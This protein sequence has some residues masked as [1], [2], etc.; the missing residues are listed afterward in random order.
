[1]SLAT[2]LRLT[3]LVLVLCCAG[4]SRIQRSHSVEEDLAGRQLWLDLKKALAAADGTEY[5]R[6]SVQDTE[7]PGGTRGVYLFRATVLS[8]EPPDKPRKIVLAISDKTTPEV[9]LQFNAPLSQKSPVGTEVEFSGVAKSFASDP[10]ML[11]F[12]ALKF[13][14]SH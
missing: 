13:R 1:M 2:T 5:F 9:T 8:W 12:E 6:T 11:T 4:F 3:S 10:F 7:V 14:I